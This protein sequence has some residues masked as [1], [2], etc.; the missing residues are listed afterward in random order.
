[1]LLEK[2]QKFILAHGFGV[3]FH[4]QAVSYC[5][6]EMRQ[7][8]MEQGCGGAKHGIWEAEGEG[9]HPREKSCLLDRALNCLCS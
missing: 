2:G 1:M 9:K 3:Q 8:F 7:N 6:S 4:G 5:V